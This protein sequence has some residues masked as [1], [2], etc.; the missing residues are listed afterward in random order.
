M[1]GLFEN[2]FNFENFLK[3]ICLLYK[4]FK[5]DYLPM[6]GLIF[7]ILSDSWSSGTLHHKWRPLLAQ[8]T[9][10]KNVRNILTILI[11]FKLIIVRIQ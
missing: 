3:V 7:F 1:I 10:W 11:Q 5:K 4:D 2:I 6:K 8:R 9:P